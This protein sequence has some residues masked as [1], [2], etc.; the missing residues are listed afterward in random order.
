MRYYTFAY[1][2]DNDLIEYETVSEVDILDH[3]TDYITKA[4]VQHFKK[5]PT[6][7]DILNEWILVRWAWATDK[8]G[9]YIPT[10]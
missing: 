9:N 10:A 3:Y 6:K 1:I 4:W 5:E 7:Q 8:D 2:G